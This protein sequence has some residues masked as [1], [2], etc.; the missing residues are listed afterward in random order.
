MELLPQ[1]CF[2]DF[3]M[4]SAIRSVRLIP[5]AKL[6]DPRVFLGLISFLEAAHAGIDQ[7]KDPPHVGQGV[8][9]VA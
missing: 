6:F 9:K 5:D 4:L 7:R 3:V 2:I 8:L 1:P